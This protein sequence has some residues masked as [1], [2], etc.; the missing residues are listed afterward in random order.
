MR[1]I[2][3][4]AGSANRTLVRCLF[5]LL[6]LAGALSLARTGAAQ[7]AGLEV[8]ARNRDGKTLDLTSLLSPN[9]QGWYR[10]NPITVEVT[11]S[12][13]AGGQ[14][15]FGVLDFS[16]KSSHFA[17]TGR[18]YVYDVSSTPPSSCSS[19]GSLGSSYSTF[20]ARCGTAL[21][22]G[23][24]I[25]PPGES[26]TMTWSVWI[27]PSGFDRFKVDAEWA[28]RADS[29]VFSA[30][31]TAIRPLVFVHG[32]LSSQ[33]PQYRLLESDAEMRE[34]LDPLAGIYWP[35]HDTMVKMGCVWGETLFSQAYDWRESNRVSG[36]VLAQ[37]LG[38]VAGRVEGNTA[39]IQDGKVDLLV[40]SMGGLVARAYIQGEATKINPATGGE[41]P[42]AY[43]NDVHQV[44]FA[45]TPHKGF[46]FDYQTW[47]GMTWDDYLYNAPL[48]PAIYQFLMDDVIWPQLVEKR[49]QPTSTELLL[50][51]LCGPSN[52]GLA[53]SV[54][55][56]A[57]DGMW[58]HEFFRAFG[59]RPF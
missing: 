42:V 6:C 39:V 15:C 52:V 58:S 48:L 12:C 29:T 21:P 56:Q 8:H 31:P 41:V 27:Q 54:I 19:I 55:V 10:D 9:E 36:G 25:V 45:A 1:F 33:P 47:E 46:P 57:Q 22:T 4:C 11:A 13:A 34:V 26:Q 38:T 51:P 5:V 43:G 49:Y 20:L 30:E 18:F 37:S 32:I 2:S 53:S 50:N 44:I 16:F 3:S 17:G 28:G 59:Y 35:I 40:H 7:T 24:L 14:E 23:L